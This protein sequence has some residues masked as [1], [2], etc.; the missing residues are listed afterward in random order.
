MRILLA[1]HWYREIFSFVT[2]KDC[3]QWTGKQARETHYCVSPVQY[4]LGNCAIGLKLRAKLNDWVCNRLSLLTVCYIIIN[5][6]IRCNWFGKFIIFCW[7]W[8]EPYFFFIS[9][10]DQ[11][12]HSCRR[13]K[14]KINFL[15]LLPLLCCSH[16]YHIIV[17][18][19][20]FITK[21]LRTHKRPFHFNYQ[22]EYTCNV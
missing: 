22:F 3:C 12:M 2:P 16:G 18:L 11:V 21:N 20:S 17:Q 13:S 5:P 19:F 4:P 8:F 10:A 15:L 7:P 9:K 6:P 1:V 14:L